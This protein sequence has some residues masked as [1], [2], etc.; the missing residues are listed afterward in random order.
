MEQRSL[1]SPKEDD[2][3]V[4][5]VSFDANVNKLVVGSFEVK[6]TSFQLK[7]CCELGLELVMARVELG[8]EQG[9]MLKNGCDNTG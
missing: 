8:A 1:Y 2:A 9:D 4:L 5:V 7:K 6:P 3:S